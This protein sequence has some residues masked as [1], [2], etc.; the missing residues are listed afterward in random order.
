MNVV[1]TGATGFIGRPLCTELTGRGHVVTAFTRNPERAQSLL[2]QSIQCIAWT[3]GSDEEAPW[4]SAIGAAD[5]VIHLAGQSVGEKAWTPEVKEELRRS[6]IEPTRSL[7]DAMAASESRPHT[8]V[9]ASGINYYGDGGE[10]V[11]TEESPPGDTFLA[12]LCID[13]E[14]EAIKAEALGIRVVRQRAGIVLGHGGP[15]HKML[16]P[17]PMPVSP[18]YLGVGGPIGN[19]RQWF[20]WIHLDDAVGMFAWSATEPRVTGAVNT[21]APELIRNVEFSRALGRA[22]HRPAVFP[23]PGFV[24]KSI[25]G[26]FADELMTSQR[27]EPAVARALGY[28][29]KYPGIDAALLA[30][31]TAQAK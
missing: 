29:Y 24:L 3:G 18:W 11:L 13:W 31:L 8:L 27:A 15:L 28:P 9:C 22:I 26:S 21:V 1:V 4:R 20:P 14:A 25:V 17:L 5:A 19:G 10:K 7:V 30:I 12:R 23:I 16:F 6:R 2:G